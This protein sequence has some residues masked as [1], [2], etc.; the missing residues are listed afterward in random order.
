MNVE[1]DIGIDNVLKYINLKEEDVVLYLG[2]RLDDDDL[3]PLSYCKYLN[4]KIKELNPTKIIAHTHWYP[5]KYYERG[6]LDDTTGIDMVLVHYK[7]LRDGSCQSINIKDYENHRAYI[8]KLTAKNLDMIY[9]IYKCETNRYP[10]AGDQDFVEINNTLMDFFDVNY[11]FKNNFKYFYH[12]RAYSPENLMEGHT[13]FRG[14]MISTDGFA[15]INGFLEA[16]FKNLNIIGFSAYGAHEDLSYHTAYGGEDYRFF[17]RKYFDLDTSENQ[18]VEAD[19]LQY[20]L[21]TKKVNN[22][23]D[24]DKFMY[25]LKEEK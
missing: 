22:L 13:E 25:Y 23:E 10:L 14:S 21:Q 16:G 18:R 1:L 2:G 7:H 17:G 3:N 15:V 24:Y 9:A 19:V 11:D 8:R 4:A 20:Y 12:D 5:K 6:V